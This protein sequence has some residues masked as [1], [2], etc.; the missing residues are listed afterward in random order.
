MPLNPKRI[1]RFGLL[2][3]ENW[4]GKADSSVPLAQGDVIERY[5]TI[6]PPIAILKR[7]QG[8]MV[9]ATIK[10]YNV[11]VLSQSCD[12]EQCKIENALICPVTVLSDFAK[13]LPNFFPVNKPDKLEKA[14]QDLKDGHIIGA[15][16]LEECNLPELKTHPLVV[17]FQNAMS[18]PLKFLKA[19]VKNQQNYRL[20]L[21]PPYRE[22][23]SQSFARFFMR[24]GLPVD[25]DVKRI[26]HDV[27]ATYNNQ[28]NKE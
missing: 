12:I 26:S 5:P 25:I 11:I 2:S 15:C 1:R 17:E 16:L 14:L 19:F 20:T 24:V 7:R 6:I 4:W 3:E 13:G 9:K 8:E 21:L 22:R 27:S 10:L 23:L 18:T 28:S